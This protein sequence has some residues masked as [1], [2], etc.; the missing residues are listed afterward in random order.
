MVCSASE[1]ER[2]STSFD[3]AVVKEGRAVRPMMLGQ[4]LEVE[5]GARSH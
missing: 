5:A 2:S 4:Q 1:Q 3:H